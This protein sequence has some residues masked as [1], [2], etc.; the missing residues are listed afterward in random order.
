MV[1]MF[2]YCWR[3]FTDCRLATCI[4]VSVD[5]NQHKHGRI[6]QTTAETKENSLVHLK[7]ENSANL[8][9]REKLFKMTSMRNIFDLH[10]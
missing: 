2:A 10:D 1:R 6:N 3:R 9:N 7:I 5:L 8:P 4:H